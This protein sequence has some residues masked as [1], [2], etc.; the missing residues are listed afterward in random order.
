MLI[1]GVTLFELVGDTLATQLA[2][3]SQVDGR[4]GQGVWFRA[5]TDLKSKDSNPGQE[6][7]GI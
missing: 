1:S 7:C 2:R 5:V 4:D 6:R 3:V